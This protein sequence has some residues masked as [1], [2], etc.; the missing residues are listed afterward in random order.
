MTALS[1]SQPVQIGN[2]TYARAELD[3]IARTV[4]KDCDPDEF[5]QFIMTASRLRLDPLRRQ[6]YAFVFSKDKP[7]KRNMVIVVGIDGFRTVAARSGDYR[8]DDQ[9]PRFVFDDAAK[10]PARNPTGLVSAE[11]SVY[12]HAHGGW[13]PVTAIAFWDEFAPLVEGGEWQESSSGKRF[14]KGDGTYRLDPKKEAWHRMPRVMLAKCA[15]VQALRRGWPD[16]LSNV[17]EQA[18]LDQAQ[19]IDLTPAEYAE[20]GAVER[21]LER[22][23]GKESIL[24]DWFGEAGL[25]PTPIGQVADRVAAFIKDHGS[26]IVY[27]RERNAH[28]LREFWARNPT[29]ALEV[30]KMIEAEE[31]KAPPNILAAG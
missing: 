7:D 30:K 18:E 24:F 21:R 5:N 8:P 27:W 26:E 15:E 14:F 29:D 20:Q 25:E 23:S 28:P 17:Y 4:A 1:R 2:S 22:I 9:A 6:I 3:L 31:R 19:T 12:R 10:D 13:F 11:V 16:D